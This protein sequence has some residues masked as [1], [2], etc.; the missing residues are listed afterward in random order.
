MASRQ[1][2]I[3][4]LW[5]HQYMKPV[6]RQSDRESLIE[7][8]WRKVKKTANCWLWTAS[9]AHTGYGK[10]SVSRSKWKPAHR[11]SWELLRGPIPQ[12]SIVIHKCG[13]PGCVNPD[14][15]FLGT[16]EDLER[17]GRP[18]TTIAKRFWPKV[19]KTATCWL[20]IG[21]IDRKGYGKIWRW[22]QKSAVASRVSWELHN[23]PIPKGMNVLH[24]CDNPACVRPDHLFLGTIG[25][26]NRDRYAKGR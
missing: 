18:V 9:V 11:V 23:G 19:K 22:P 3:E 2:S 20:W 7:R 4:L 21:H 25:D 10:I 6:N 13:N 8:F 14:H 1:T 12:G 15:L 24:R 16:Q 26:N 17:E 5:F